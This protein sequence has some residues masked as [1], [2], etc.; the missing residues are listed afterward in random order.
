MIQKIP[1]LALSLLLATNITLGGFLSALHEHWSAWA[2]VSLCILLLGAV[3]SCSWATMRDSFA[4]LLASDFKAFLV[5][6]L[7]A[8][9]GVVIV[10]WLHTFAHLLVIICAFLLAKIDLQ[11]ANFSDR[12]IF[13]TICFISLLGLFLGGLINYLISTLILE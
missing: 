9:L 6:V 3:L 10:F 5:A 11:A 13:R 12:Q 7:V 4:Y 8:F 1:W 2:V